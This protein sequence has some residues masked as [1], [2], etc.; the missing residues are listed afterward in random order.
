[1]KKRLAI[2][3]ASELGNQIAHY[4]PISVNKY[5][6]VG[7]FDDFANGDLILGKVADIAA[8]YERDVFDCLIVGV[9]Y[10]SMSFRSTIFNRYCGKIPFATI[11]HPSCYVD[12][13]AIIAEGCVL[14]P[15][16]TIDKNVRLNGNALVNLGCVIAHDSVVGQDT[17]IAPSVTVAGFCVIG[18]QNFIG[19]GAVVKDGVEI[20]GNVVIGAGTII[21]SN[22]VESGTYVGV[23]AKRIK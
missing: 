21:I 5:E 19:V 6:V 17:F 8:V 7:F 23:P 18:E 9:G 3:G 16:V 13:T 15:H 10:K 22:V 14:Y 12:E 2:I 20:I 11:I 1:M 4:A